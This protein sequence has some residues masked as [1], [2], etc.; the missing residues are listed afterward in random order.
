MV[1]R[2]ILFSSLFVWVALSSVTLSQ[3]KITDIG[4]DDWE[5][6]LKGE[7]MVEFFAPWCPACR[8][9]RPVWG[10]FSEWADDLGLDGVAHVDVTENPGLSGRFIVT[11]LPTIFHV[12]DGEFRQYRGP[13]DRDSFISYIEEKKWMEVDPLPSWKNPNSFPMTILSY[14][15]KGSMLLKSVHTTITEDYGYSVWV[16]YAAFAIST[17]IV[18]A[19]LGM[20]LVLII[21]C[22]YP[23]DKFQPQTVKQPDG[24]NKDGKSDDT[25]NEEELPE[26]DGDDKAVTSEKTEDPVSTGAVRKRRAKRAD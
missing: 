26:D 17:I 25:E 18:G 8:A 5:M 6:L 16:S 9:L 24:D 1:S 2:A 3:A 4:E 10:Q 15:F 20:L 21:D 14:F 13:R 7:W 11:A 12:K 19:A 23:V 22:V